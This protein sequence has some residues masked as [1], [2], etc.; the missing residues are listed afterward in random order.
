MNGGQKKTA[1]LWDGEQDKPRAASPE[2]YLIPRQPESN[3]PETA[4][5]NAAVCEIAGLI[6]AHTE[7]HF[8]G[9]TEAELQAAFS[10]DVSL[11]GPE[12]DELIC[13]V[14]WLAA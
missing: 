11:Q 8:K 14:A 6:V 3:L 13:K 1:E 12:F 4:G 2:V 10:K 7:D 5:F 9:F